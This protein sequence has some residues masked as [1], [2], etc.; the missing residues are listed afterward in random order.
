MRFNTAG[1]NHQGTV[2]FGVLI[3][4]QGPPV[5]QGPF[6]G[7]PLGCELPLPTGDVFESHLIG[8]NHPGPGAGFDAHIADGH[9]GFHRQPAHGLAAVFK[10]VS[11][12]AGGPHGTDNFQDHILG[13]N[14]GCKTA[15]KFHLVSLRFAL[16]KGLSDQH[17]LNFRSPDTES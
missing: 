16:H 10:H 4:W 14:V 6:Q 8:G 13:E 7:I 2:K 12:A 9:A 1:I 15:G 11:G 17:V 3:T 5:G